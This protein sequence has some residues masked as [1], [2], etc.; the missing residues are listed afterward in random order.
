MS[1]ALEGGHVVLLLWFRGVSDKIII[2]RFFSIYLQDRTD[3]HQSRK[4]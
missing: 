3:S 2:K 1:G 4:N